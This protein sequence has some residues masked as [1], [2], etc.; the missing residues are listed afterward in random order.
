MD[1]PNNASPHPVKN[2][3]NSLSFIL[4]G[5]VP[6]CQN[7]KQFVRFFWKFYWSLLNI[8]T[9]NLGNRIFQG[10]GFVQENSKTL[11][12]TFEV[13]SRKSNVNISRKL[14]KLILGLWSFL[15]IFGTIR[16]FLE[17]RSR[18]FFSSHQTLL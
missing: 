14:K 15:P 13:I 7:W 1:I 17:N 8:L 4:C 16:I 11:K 10:M 12:S 2:N 3:N 6:A 5:F 9:Y 18:F